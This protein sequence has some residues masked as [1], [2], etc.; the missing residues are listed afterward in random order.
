MKKFIQSHKDKRNDIKTIEKYFAQKHPNL[1][2][3]K[4]FPNQ[5][6]ATL[7]NLSK[8]GI[9]L[10]PP[11]KHY[12]LIAS[13]DVSAYKNENTPVETMSQTLNYLTSHANCS[14]RIFLK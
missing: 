11:P 7:K 5:F 2:K 12:G 13:V 6:K 10:L 14:T 8:Q 4:T 9:L 3:E 1:A